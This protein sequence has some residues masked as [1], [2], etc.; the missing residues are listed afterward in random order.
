M[1]FQSVMY[2][3]FSLFFFAEFQD[4]HVIVFL[5]FG[6]LSTFLIRYGFSAIGFNLL[7]AATATQWAIIL[8]GME[9][10]YYRGKISINLRR[11][12][13]VVVLHFEFS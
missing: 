1:V 5:G 10:W 13:A 3:W 12:V 6:F 4:V 7:V 8:S 9:A 2:V 11:W